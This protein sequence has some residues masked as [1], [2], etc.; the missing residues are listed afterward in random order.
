M[1]NSLNVHD[2]VQVTLRSTT[3]GG[4][5]PFKTLTIAA[6]DKNEQ[7]TEITLF[8]TDNSVTPTITWEPFATS[9]SS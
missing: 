2:V 1:L 7:K 3:F 9:V 5:S 8:F 4:P 6:F